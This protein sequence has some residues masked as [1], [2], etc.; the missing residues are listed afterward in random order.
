MTVGASKGLSIDAAKCSPS[1]MATEYAVGFASTGENILVR[2]NI[3]KPCYV[4]AAVHT[5]GRLFAVLVHAHQ[6]RL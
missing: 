5:V 3:G 2:R 4:D 6:T 1:D